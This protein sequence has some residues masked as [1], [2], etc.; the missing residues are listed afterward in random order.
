M[1]SS[2][3]QTYVSTISFLFR[4]FVT[5]WKDDHI[6]VASY[7]WVMNIHRYTIAPMDMTESH[8]NRYSLLQNN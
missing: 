8:G 3:S 1:K 7:P 6:D 4:Q 2:S 5:C